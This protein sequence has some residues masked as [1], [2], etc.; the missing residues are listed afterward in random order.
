[1][2]NAGGEQKRAMRL[3]L[4]VGV[5]LLAV[6]VGAW[7][8]TGSAAILSDAAESVLHVAAVGFAAFSL[9]L[10][11]RPATEQFPYGYERVSFFS[12]GFE[13]GMIVLA[14]VGILLETIRKWLG[15]L[16][17]QH[18]G[19]GAW[20]VA[21]AGAVNGALGW[22]LIRTGRRVNS[23]IL[24]ANGKHVM[25]DC[26][27]SIGVLAGL[28]A[29]ILTERQFFDPLC[30]IA[31]ACNILWSG[32]RLV[33]DSIGG[34]MD[35]SDPQTGE[36]IRARLQ[37]ICQELGVQHHQLRFRY[38]GGRMMIEVHL[39]F[40]YSTPLGAAHRVATQVEDRLIADLRSPAEVITHLE[41]LEDHADVHRT[42]SRA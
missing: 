41:A 35:Y 22:H 19:S 15:G 38:T 14:A 3:S 26:W 30:A 9:C 13:G 42:R 32:G 40:P 10:S 31:V 29:V 25:T 21:A 27:T 16:E 8:F 39:L 2:Q 4:A 28:L 34:L 7:W 24:I 18:L 11:L 6:K 23:L 17:L 36:A 37:T 33:R 20:A 1:M 12:A 5:G